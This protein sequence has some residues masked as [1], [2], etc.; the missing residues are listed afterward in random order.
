MAITVITGPPGAGKTTVSALVARHFARSVHL[1]ADECFGWLASGFVAPWRPESDEQNATV[2]DVIGAAAWAYATGGYE[3]VVDGIVGPWFLARFAAAAHLDPGELAYVVIRPD[4]T[5]A[6][7]RAV[8]RRAPE[9]LVEPGP[10]AAMFDAF[11]SLGAFEDNVVDSSDLDAA[12]TAA[13]VLEAIRSGRAI[14]GESQRRDMAR[15]RDPQAVPPEGTGTL[16]PS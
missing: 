13:A 2:I 4:R 10:I 11:E 6:H 15:L 1:R 5:V 8:A 16:A 9:D 12:A 3:V 7:A 14:V